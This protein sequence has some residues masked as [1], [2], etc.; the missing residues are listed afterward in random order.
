MWSDGKKSKGVLM[1]LPKCRTC[2]FFAEQ[3]IVLPEK[4]QAPNS[5]GLC[6]R[7]APGQSLVIAPSSP[8]TFQVVNAW[9]PVTKNDGCGE[10]SD[11]LFD[12]QEKL[13]LLTGGIDS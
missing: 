3:K 4:K 2:L 1:T 10:H 5:D 12:E 13:K 6:R 11:F 9:Y 7:L 8:T